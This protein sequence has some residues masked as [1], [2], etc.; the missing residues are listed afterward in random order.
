VEYLGGYARGDALPETIIKEGGVDIDL[1]KES[2]DGEVF[3][4][5]L[6]W[7][8]LKN[9]VPVSTLLVVLRGLARDAHAQCLGAPP[10]EGTLDA[11]ALDVG[12]KEV[13]HATGTRMTAAIG[14][15]WSVRSLNEIVEAW[16]NI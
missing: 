15:G 6:A 2:R 4:H 5:Y 7:Y 16:K 11:Q 8:L 12:I 3:N 10:P 9:G 14:S 1:E 13:L